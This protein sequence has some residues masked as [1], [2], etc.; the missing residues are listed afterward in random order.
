MEELS[1]E[2]KKYI[3]SGAL[4][5]KFKETDFSELYQTSQIRHFSNGANIIAQGEHAESMYV[6]L[7]GEVEVYVVNPSGERL[8]LAILHPGDTVGEDALDPDSTHERS[9]NVIALTHVKVIEISGF[10]LAK[11][12]YLK[13]SLAQRR[14]A[15]TYDQM[16]KLMTNFHMVQI[17][18]DEIGYIH[19]ESFQ[20]GSVIFSEGEEGKAIY[21]ILNGSIRLTKK[22]GGKEKVIGIVGKNQ[23]VGEVA[24]LEQQK[25][26]ATAI[27]EENTHLLRVDKDLFLKWYSAYPIFRDMLKSLKNVYHFQDDSLIS[28]YTGQYEGKDCIN[29]IRSLRNGDKFISVKVINEET[30]IFYKLIKAEENQIKR[31]VYESKTKNIRRELQLLDNTLIGI[32]TTGPWVRLSQAVNKIIK[33]EQI[34]FS[35]IE[36]FKQRGEINLEYVSELISENSIVCQCMSVTYKDVCHFISKYGDNVEKI[37]DATGATLVC[38]GCKAV[39]N[40]LLG[41]SE[42]LSLSMISSELIAND[43]WLLKLQST[44]DDLPP[45]LP[46]QHIMLKTKLGEDWV[47]RSYTLMPSSNKNTW[48]IMVLRQPFGMMSNLLTKKNS[49]PIILQASKPMGHFLVGSE[50]KEVVFFAAG[51][52]VTPALAILHTCTANFFLHYSAATEADFVL[53]DELAKNPN[54]KLHCTSTEGHLTPGQIEL[55]LQDHPEANIMLCGSPEYHRML[56]SV[57]NDLKIPASRIKV[58][59]FVPDE[60][61]K[62]LKK[63]E[64]INYILPVFTS[65]SPDEIEI[66]LN[67]IYAAFNVFSVFTTRLKNVR[68]E[69]TKYRFFT[70]TADEIHI[71]IKKI[72]LNKK[73]N[74]SHLHILD[75]RNITSL[76]DAEQ[77]ISDHQY[78]SDVSAS[79]IV[80]TIISN[81]I[82][83]NA[84]F[85]IIKIKLTSFC[86]LTALVTFPKGFNVEDP[87]KYIP[88]QPT[89]E[90]VPVALDFRAIWNFRMIKDFIMNPIKFL[91]EFTKTYD[92]HFSLRIP[93]RRISQIYYLD[94]DIAHDFLTLPPEI[95]KIAPSIQ[96]NDAVGLWFKRSRQDVEWLQ[97]L[98]LACREM[99]EEN[100]LNSQKLI[101]TTL[102]TSLTK[103]NMMEW[104]E[105]VELVDVLVKLIY[106][107]S[108][109]LILEEKL[110]GDMK[111]EAIPLFKTMANSLD[112]MRLLRAELP[113]V[114][115]MPEYCAVK[116]LEI[117][118][119]KVIAN[120][121]NNSFLKM[122]QQIQVENVP[123]SPEDLPWVLMYF[124]WNAVTYPGIYGVWCLLHILYDDEIYKDLQ[125]QNIEKKKLFISD[126]LTETLRLNPVVSQVRKLSCPIDYH[127]SKKTYYIPKDKDVG[128]FPYALCH[129]KD[130]YSNPDAFN[131]LRYSSGEKKPDLLFGKGPFSCVGKQYTYSL[132]TTLLAEILDSYHFKLITKPIMPLSRINLLYPNKPILAKLTKK[133]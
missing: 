7:E 35:S 121:P 75:K 105:E 37:I 12:H 4:F 48:E 45:A 13:D 98:I 117:L 22:K 106:E 65:E 93:G 72:L 107:V 125:S 83:I 96:I 66:F 36:L 49:E 85:K 55:M 42:W 92:G 133:Q 81:K 6:I 57:L 26:F 68:D 78:F 63:Q 38:G 77:I 111:T 87:L 56:L 25:R 58:E 113:L 118:I 103:N 60:P 70:P 94:T 101:N 132:L 8:V 74:I 73:M 120:H 67:D 28:V 119:E 97:S 108:T 32:I 43:I 123:L 51:I 33:G 99:L 29:T 54:V 59:S 44:R 84:P 126:C 110:W 17:V 9:A 109:S 1:V 3:E 23:C 11:Y 116:K 86:E 16:L 18:P 79:N 5:Q 53:K 127:V 27:A 21:F 19:E 15:H 122:L 129:D 2:E 128:I 34:S 52:G 46:G 20:T 80:I 61:L 24:L 10:F 115:I 39:I 100:V 82:Q 102:I 50:T 89:L 30:M 76:T 69:I 95:A 91:A 90:D 40:D 47:Q 64:K 124:I 114:S 112:A 130:L 41:K 71:G 104:S 62:A 31:F 131:P 88:D 14:S